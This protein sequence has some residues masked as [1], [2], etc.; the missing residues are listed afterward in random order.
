MSKRISIPNDVDT[1]DA[2]EHI[3]REARLNGYKVV[4]YD[5]DEH[6]G[7]RYVVIERKRKI[8]VKPKA[9]FFA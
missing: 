8:K 2:V 9:R 7:H 3:R 1:R 6:S 4:D 5:L